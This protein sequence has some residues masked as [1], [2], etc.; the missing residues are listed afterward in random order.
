MKHNAFQERTN[1]C[2]SLPLCFPK[3]V[4]TI[5]KLDGRNSE[6]DPRNKNGKQF[7]ISSEHHMAAKASDLVWDIDAKQQVTQWGATS[8]NPYGHG[9]DGI[10]IL[11]QHIIRIILAKWLTKSQREKKRNNF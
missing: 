6:N 7:T 10:G 4:G 11:K 1:R 8:P 5:H 2:Q 9:V 3:I